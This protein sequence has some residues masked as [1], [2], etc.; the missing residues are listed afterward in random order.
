ML[1]HIN[2]VFKNKKIEGELNMKEIMLDFQEK[3]EKKLAEDKKNEE[4]RINKIQ[5]PSCKSNDKEHIVKGDNNGI[6][7]PGYRS[8]IIEE[9]YVC[10]SCGTMFKDLTKA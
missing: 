6:F 4:A 5:C 1:A 9:Y 2:E 10:Q 8:W 7:G 3:N